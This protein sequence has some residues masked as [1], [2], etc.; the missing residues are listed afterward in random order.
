MKVW[1]LEDEPRAVRRLKR[2]LTEQSIS[3]EVTGEFDSIQSAEPHFASGNFPDVIL[4]DIELADGLS[5]VLHE[6]Y[7]PQCPVI[8]TT[9]YDQYA[10]NAFRA[11][12]VDY[13]LKP[14]QPEALGH[15]L[16]KAQK[17]GNAG[18]VSLSDL[19]S[20]LAARTQERRTRFMVRVGEKL[21]SI[22][23]DEVDCFYSEDKH[24]LLRSGER[25]YVLD[26]TLDQIEAD[27]D[28]QAF[29]RIS[30]KYLIAHRAMADVVAYSN[31]RFRIVVRGW[32]RTDVVVARDRAADFKKWLGA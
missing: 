21:K 24:T 14:V 31:S 25:E 26:R 22:S 13:L 11:N 10:L 20:M 6:K 17:L 4:S 7:P 15:A 32:N 29:F 28:P 2:L 3:S 30:R 19:Q 27:I 9:A 23:M 16:T 8:F 5:F 18:E 1:I 12:G